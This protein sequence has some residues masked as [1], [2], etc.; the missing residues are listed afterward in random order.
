MRKTYLATVIAA[1]GAVAAPLAATVGERS[2]APIENESELAGRA[3]MIAAFGL[4]IIIA[5]VII[6]ADDEDDP[7]SA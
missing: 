1:M 4:A 2:V 6:I 5:G 3:T 7:L